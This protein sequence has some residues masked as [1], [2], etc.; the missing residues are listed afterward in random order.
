MRLK[1]GSSPKQSQRQKLL[2]ASAAVLLFLA[3]ILFVKVDT[4]K[5]A[6]DWKTHV[7]IQSKE[8]KAAKSSTESRILQLVEKQQLLLKIKKGKAET[9]L[10]EIED[11]LRLQR[12]LKDYQEKL[13]LLD[14]TKSTKKEKLE[15]K[16]QS[17]NMEVQKLKKQIHE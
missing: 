16:I 4:G 8:A 12:S 2:N 13:R 14:K 5:A 3:A 7:Q 1:L 17:L 10:Q 15:Q 6:Y 11:E 9:E